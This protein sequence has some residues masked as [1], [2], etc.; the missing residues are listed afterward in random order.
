MFNDL[1][2]MERND[3][4]VAPPRER[5]LRRGAVLLITVFL[6]GGLYVGIQFFE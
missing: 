2:E 4:S 1:D 3:Q 6:F 5:W